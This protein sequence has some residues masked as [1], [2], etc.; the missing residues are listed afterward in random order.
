MF[1]QVKPSELAAD[2]RFLVT[3]LE[4]LPGG[5]IRLHYRHDLLVGEFDCDPAM[6]YV[7][8]KGRSEGK[9]PKV[10]YAMTH[11]RTFGPPGA[12]GRVTVERLSYEVV[13]TPIQVTGRFTEETTYS[14]P[15]VGKTGDLDEER[16]RLTHYG[17]PEPEGVVW[18][19]PRSYLAYWL[20]GAGALLILMTTWLL[21]RR[22]IGPG[23]NTP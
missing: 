21:R 14:Y 13:G 12:D 4:R 3:K 6:H 7:I 10:G 23:R 1:D 11:E 17:L 5:L 15:D 22:R 20:A 9:G 16:F 18:P 8:K 19:K 2:A